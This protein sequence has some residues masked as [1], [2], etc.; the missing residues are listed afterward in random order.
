MLYIFKYHLS[1]WITCLLNSTVIYMF[2]GTEQILTTRKDA[3]WGPEA[4]DSPA[5][6]TLG[7]SEPVITAEL[8]QC[9]LCLPSSAT[10]WLTVDLQWVST[11]WLT[12]LPCWIKLWAQT[13]LDSS[14]HSQISHLPDPGCCPSIPSYPLPVASPKGQL[15]APH[16]SWSSDGHK[17]NPNSP[18]DGKG[19]LHSKNKETTKETVVSSK[20]TK[21]SK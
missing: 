14:F 11:H 21:H 16:L 9:L 5:S 2:L 3:P 18:E 7:Y 8:I 12:W 6:R 15:S 20:H 17:W 10:S 13:E 1:A 19:G 4:H